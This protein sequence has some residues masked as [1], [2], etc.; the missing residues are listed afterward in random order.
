[1]PPAQGGGG[2][3]RTNVSKRE[4]FVFVFFQE[5]YPSKILSKTTLPTINKLVIF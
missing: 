1:M 3:P 5:N 4:V 2:T